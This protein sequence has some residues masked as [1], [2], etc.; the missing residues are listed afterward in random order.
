MSKIINY[1]SHYLWFLT[2][3]VI[4]LT[5]TVIFLVCYITIAMSNIAKRMSPIH[6]LPGFAKC[7]LS[8]FPWLVKHDRLKHWRTIPNVS[9][10]KNC[11]IFFSKIRLSGLQKCDRSKKLNSRN[12]I[13]YYQHFVWSFQFYYFCLSQFVV[14]TNIFLIPQ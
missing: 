11:L 2:I 1:R 13:Q 14:T 4:K 12:S 3:T 8:P 5:S 9:A 7:W 6:Y 10:V